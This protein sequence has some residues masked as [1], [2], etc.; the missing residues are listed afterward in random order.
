M[1][2]KY[3]EKCFPIVVIN[4]ISCIITTWCVLRAT[5]STVVNVFIW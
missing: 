1:F 3:N 5:L 4:I 2:K